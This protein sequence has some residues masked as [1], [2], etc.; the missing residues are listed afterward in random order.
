MN[1]KNPDFNK[2]RVKVQG[3]VMAW[4]H[5]GP[6]RSQAQ[7]AKAININP[8]T[9]ST[10]LTGKCQSGTDKRAIEVLEAFFKLEDQR[11][12]LLPEPDFI[13]TRQARRVQNF[14]SMI[15]V[16]RGIGVLHGSSGIGKTITIKDYMRD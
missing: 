3:R 9:L 11:V 4:L 8:A 7:L 5:G 2:R 6:A 1:N 15:H 14:I 10:F 13:Y 16:S 12:D